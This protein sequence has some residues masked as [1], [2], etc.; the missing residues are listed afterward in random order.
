[1]KQLHLFE[2]RSAP[3]RKLTRKRVERM[4]EH[5][6]PWVRPRRPKLPDA[7]FFRSMALRGLYV[8][9]GLIEKP[10]PRAG[11]RQPSERNG[12]VTHFEPFEVRTYGDVDHFIAAFGPALGVADRRTNLDVRRRHERR[13]NERRNERRFYNRRWIERERRHSDSPLYLAWP[14][15]DR[16]RDDRFRLYDRRQF[17]SPIYSAWPILNRRGRRYDEDF[18]RC[19]DRRRQ[20]ERRGPENRRTER[21]LNDWRREIDRRKS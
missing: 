9:E 17:D 21:R 10:M 12:K 20:G 16:R 11:V 13:Q 8:L 3:K 1:M 2:G 18:E 19:V 7:P 15:L 14:V 5:A 6:V 4:A